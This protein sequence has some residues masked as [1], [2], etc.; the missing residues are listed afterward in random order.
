MKRKKRTNRRKW[1]IAVTSILIGVAIPVMLLFNLA[2]SFSVDFNSN[3]CPP[4][5]PHEFE[6]I[7]RFSL[8]SSYMNLSSKC[9]TWQDWGAFAAFD[10]SPEDLDNYI[11]YVNRWL[12]SD[13]DLVEFTTDSDEFFREFFILARRLRDNNIQT[14][15]YGY[16]DKYDVKEIL[17]DTTNPEK[18]R[19][20][21]NTFGF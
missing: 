3:E 7:A 8:P 18:Y 9:S 14:G 10:I 6:R 13:T 19:V 20:T 21:I 12:G 1:I 2:S 17:I 5:E 4:D 15:L 11:V 16:S